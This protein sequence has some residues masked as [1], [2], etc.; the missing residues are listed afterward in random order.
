MEGYVHKR[1]ENKLAGW[2][3]G[4]H[5]GIRHFV[6]DQQSDYYQLLPEKE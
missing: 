4:R 2:Y 1:E 6:Q 3:T 5:T